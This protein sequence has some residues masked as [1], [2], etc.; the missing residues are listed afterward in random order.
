MRTRHLLRLAL[1]LALASAAAFGQKGKSA[2]NGAWEVKAGAQTYRITFEVD[3]G[4]VR[5]TVTLP[6]GME[7]DV[8]YGFLFGN[9]LEFTTVEGGVEYE[10]TGKVSR[11][12]V[13]G[14][15]LN[16]DDDTTVGFSAK[17]AR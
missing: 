6:G 7:T 10:W 5:G 14:E 4:D 17:R 16:L 2:L 8:E 12:S 9:E 11:N 15:R 1:A 13:R 3:D